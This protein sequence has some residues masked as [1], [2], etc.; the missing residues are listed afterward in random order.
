[1]VQYIITPPAESGQIVV[2]MGKYVLFKQAP[3]FP[4]SYLLAR[5]RSLQ[6]PCGIPPIRVGLGNQ[7]NRIDRDDRMGLEVA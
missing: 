5:S 6:P 7:Q 3:P 4:Q 1:M 2:M